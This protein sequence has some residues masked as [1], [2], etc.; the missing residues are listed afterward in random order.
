MS[1]ADCAAGLPNRALDRLTEA[2]N[3]AR[4]NDD[5]GSEAWISVHRSV[6]LRLA[7]RF[8]ETERALCDALEYYESANDVQGV[9]WA[10]THLGD[11][12]RVWRRPVEAIDAYRQLH[13]V[14]VHL[15]N[16]RLSKLATSV[17]AE[18]DGS[19]FVHNAIDHQ[20]S[21]PV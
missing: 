13:T 19:R 3:V 20:N 6:A 15:N 14:A 16:S 17:L 4:A 2:Q 11:M 18:L 1:D 12:Y 7:D 10:L 5:A 8:G 21:D 9:A